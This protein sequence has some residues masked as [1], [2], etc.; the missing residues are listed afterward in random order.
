MASKSISIEVYTT[1]HRILGR[2]APGAVYEDVEAAQLV[3]HAR[4]RRLDR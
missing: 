1:S 2:V 3:E 4:E